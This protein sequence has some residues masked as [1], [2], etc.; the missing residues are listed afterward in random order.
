MDFLI[1]EYLKKINLDTKR[2]NEFSEN[3][4][5]NENIIL[6]NLSKL[7]EKEKFFNFK[8]IVFFEKIKEN[9]KRKNNF[10]KNN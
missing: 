3:F 7:E 10:K 8:T 5:K 6:N 4:K 9:L 1:K 2:L